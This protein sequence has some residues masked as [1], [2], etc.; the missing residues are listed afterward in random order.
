MG[1]QAQTA[2]S[3][4]TSGTPLDSDNPAAQGQADYQTAVKACNRM[5][6]APRSDCLRDVRDARARNTRSDSSSGSTPNSSGGLG[7]TI[8]GGGGSRSQPLSKQ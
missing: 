4:S 2:P 3:S 8:T 1:V 7:T 6:G 5:T